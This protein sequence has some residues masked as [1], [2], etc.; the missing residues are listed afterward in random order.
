MVMGTEAFAISPSFLHGSSNDRMVS[1]AEAG[2]LPAQRP[3]S[4][5]PWQR[6]PSGEHRR[7]GWG[8]SPLHTWLEQE[9]LGG[10]EP[11]ESRLGCERDTVTYNLITQEL[12]LAT[13]GE[14]TLSAESV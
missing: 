13:G 9:V 12:S 11:G 2:G 3:C 14:Q 4:W 5:L 10:L 8:D 7:P 1:P 6:G